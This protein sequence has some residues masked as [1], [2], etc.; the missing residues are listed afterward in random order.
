MLVILKQELHISIF[1][2][3]HSACLCEVSTST[4]SDTARQPSHPGAPRRANAISR[5][6]T[7]VC[8]GC[9]MAAESE[10]YRFIMYEELACRRDWSL[11]WQE[12][13][14]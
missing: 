6:S 1:S 14:V 4:S 7:P 10:V 8:V 11:E 3:L 12:T 13:I 9:K 5:P 2:S